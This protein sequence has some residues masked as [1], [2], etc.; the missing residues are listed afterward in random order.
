MSLFPRAGPAA[1]DHLG[2]Y[3]LFVM[4]GKLHHTY[5]FVGIETY[6][7]QSD[8]TV[9]TGNVRLR[10]DF[11]ADAPVMAGHD[12]WSGAGADLGSVL[13]VIPMSG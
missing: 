10:L 1:F 8:S 2:G 9:P 7:H 12:L 11:E 13:A 4:D 3:S 6:R 5:S